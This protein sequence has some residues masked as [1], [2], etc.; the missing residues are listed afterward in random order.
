M[1]KNIILVNLPPSAKYTYESKG[2]MYPSAGLLL[3]GTL[4]KA[5][6][7]KVNFIDG[8]YEEDYSAKVKA[9]MT[10]D[11]IYVGMSVMTS[12]LLYALDLS[13]ALKKHNSDI[14]IVW[15]GVHPTLFPEMVCENKTVDIVVINEGTVA[16]LA[17]AR[18]IKAGAGLE[19]IK[20]IVF[21][22]DG[23][24][25]RTAAGE[26]DD[27]SKLPHLDF[28]LIDINRY[29]GQESIVAQQLDVPDRDKLKIFPILSGLGCAYR[30]SFCINV[31]LQ[32][33]YRR[34]SARDI[35]DEVKHLNKEYGATAFFFLDEDFFIDKK[36]IMEMLDIMEAEGVKFYWRVWMR[37]NYFNKNYITPELLTRL[38]K[39]GLL[40]MVMGA[41]SGSENI[42]RYLNKSITPEQV[43]KSAEMTA[44]SKI[45]PR[46]SFMIGLPGETKG[47]IIATY[48]LMTK[49]KRLNSKADVVVFIFRLYPGSKIYREISE[50]YDLKVPDSLQ[51]WRHLLSLE[52]YLEGFQDKWVSAS[53]MK[54]IAVLD[55]YLSLIVT[56][57]SPN[58]F[59][60][61]LVKTVFRNL[62]I[63]RFNMSFFLFPWEYYVHR[64]IQ[65]N[66]QYRSHT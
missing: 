51:K 9:L 8:A 47:E 56:G 33:K 41:E 58:W 59:K 4:L 22:K 45:T 42:L 20:G 57:T 35:I 61:V 60:R 54:L 18:A 62:A 10:S 31:I 13:E 12:Q 46:Y 39:N 37:V 15:G 19:K 6:G 30:C 5:E 44:G 29:C 32:R 23:N 28:S 64:V 17:L 49:L 24:I 11:T 55:F 1:E 3:L 63:A 52:G 2:H 50:K 7:F 26:P 34:R 14:P 65:K 21:K 53:K 27:L 36:R 66:V 25:Q 48:R 38:E 16:A 40:N 43:I